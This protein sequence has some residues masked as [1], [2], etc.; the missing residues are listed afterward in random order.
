MWHCLARVVMEFLVL[1]FDNIFTLFNERLIITRSITEY[2]LFINRYKFY[3]ANYLLKLSSSC[4][5]YLCLVSFFTF[6]VSAPVFCNNIGIFVTLIFQ[7]ILLLN[8]EFW[9]IGR[10]VKIVLNRLDTYFPRTSLFTRT[11]TIV[12][13]K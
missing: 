6:L 3:W 13:W 5:R 11:Q 8:G 4:E 9:N 2:F 12:N 1:R 7:G 10:D